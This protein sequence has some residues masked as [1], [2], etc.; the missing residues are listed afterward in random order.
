MKPLPLSICIT[1]LW[2]FII[3]L[4]NYST[5]NSSVKKENIKKENINVQQLKIID[6]SVYHKTARN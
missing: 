3:I 4:N 5:E 1:V 6:Q 2:T